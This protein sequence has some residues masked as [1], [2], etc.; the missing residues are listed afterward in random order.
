MNKDLTNAYTILGWQ[1]VAYP[2]TTLY[3]VPKSLKL[4]KQTNL[5]YTII[6]INTNTT[7]IR[8]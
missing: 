3:F 2:V 7:V 4:T 5:N 1:K 8:T 6:E